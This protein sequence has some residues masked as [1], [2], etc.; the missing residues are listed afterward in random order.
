M[1]VRK[2]VA[3]ERRI[4]LPDGRRDIEGF[5]TERDGS[6]EFHP[7][8]KIYDWLTAEGFT[9]YGVINPSTFSGALAF[10]R[11]EDFERE[12]GEVI[13]VAVGYE[14]DVFTRPELKKGGG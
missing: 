10:C 7:P 3:G 2:F 5:Y 11:L 6:L 8:V 4:V 1:M 12:G 14:W 13:A 9:R